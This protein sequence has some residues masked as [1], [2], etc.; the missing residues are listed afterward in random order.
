MNIKIKYDKHG[1]VKKV[2][3]DVG[4]T[5]MNLGALKL[6]RGEIE[7]TKRYKLR[8]FIRRAFN[9]ISLRAEA[10]YAYHIVGSPEAC[11]APRIGI[12]ER[13]YEWE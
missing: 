3:G 2:V 6:W 9:E 13:S 10:A 4:R 5:R 11:E 7:H 8:R 1:N 12:E